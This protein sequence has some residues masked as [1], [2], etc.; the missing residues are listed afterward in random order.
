AGGFGRAEALV[1]LAVLGLQDAGWAD[2]ITG[3]TDTALATLVQ[4]L[5]VPDPG[6]FVQA[7]KFTARACWNRTKD[8]TTQLR[9][10]A[11]KPTVEL[12]LAIGVAL[13]RTKSIK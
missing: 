8:L 11:D 1:A 3:G 9:F 13:C 12:G 6:V 10:A 2:I 5:F 7:E 4:P